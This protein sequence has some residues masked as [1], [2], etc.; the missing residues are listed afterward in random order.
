MDNQ[1][2]EATVKATVDTAATASKEDQALALRTLIKFAL[3]LGSAPAA[4]VAGLQLLT[5]VHMGYILSLL[6]NKQRLRMQKVLM[7]Q[8][9]PQQGMTFDGFKTKLCSAAVVRLADNKMSSAISLNSLYSAMPKEA[10]LTPENAQEAYDVISDSISLWSGCYVALL[11]A[12]LLPSET[13]ERFNPIL[14]RM[15]FLVDMELRGTWATEDAILYTLAMEQ[16]FM[17]PC[18]TNIMNLVRNL[19]DAIKTAHR[20]ELPLDDIKSAMNNMSSQLMV[21]G[22]P[23]LLWC[24]A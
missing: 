13:T 23:M 8:Q 20:V 24:D 21:S 9:A 11:I 2:F 15:L 10:M 1:D 3:C 7:V 16:N 5:S 14:D 12:A 19:P 17:F 6:L 22:E 4:L 18:I